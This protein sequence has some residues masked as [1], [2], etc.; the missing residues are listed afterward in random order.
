LQRCARDAEKSDGCLAD[1]LPYVI[2]TF[3]GQTEEGMGTSMAFFNM[4]QGDAPVL[5]RLAMEY[6]IADNYH[7][8]VMGDHRKRP[9]HT[10]PAPGRMSVLK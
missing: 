5:K 6:S 1:L 10:P 8:A 3:A 2:T 4:N 9:A 7:Q